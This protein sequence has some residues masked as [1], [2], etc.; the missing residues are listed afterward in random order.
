MHVFVKA[1]IWEKLEGG[2]QCLMEGS[3]VRKEEITK[4]N[5]TGYILEHAN[6]VNG[7]ARRV[8]PLVRG[9]AFADIHLNRTR[10]KLAEVRA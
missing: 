1:R 7:K 4:V 8:C 9:D 5:S 3:D 2:E 6:V 10:V